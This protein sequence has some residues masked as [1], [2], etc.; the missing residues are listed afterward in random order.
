VQELQ[1]PTRP[2]A[3]EV[4]VTTGTQF[5]GS[6]FVHESPYHESDADDVIDLLN[7]ERDFLPLGLTDRQD[8][9]FILSK[10][11]IVRVRL[12]MPGADPLDCASGAIP[13]DSAASTL[14]LADGSCVKGALLVATPPSTSRLVDKLNSAETFLSVASSEAIEFVRRSH[15]VHVS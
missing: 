10:A 12:E 13:A 6:L 2:I 1:V 5:S 11:H 3:V 4:F 9:P 8:G 14:F 15:V 7:D